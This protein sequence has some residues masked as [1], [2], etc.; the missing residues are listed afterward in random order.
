[1]AKPYSEHTCSMISELENLWSTVLCVATF[2]MITKNSISRLGH[3]TF[4]YG[5]VVIIE[6]VA[7]K[8]AVLH[9]FFSSEVIESICSEYDFAMMLER[10]ARITHMTSLGLVMTFEE[11]ARQIDVLHKLS[12]IC[13]QY[14]FAMS[15]AMG[16]PE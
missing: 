10:V 7:T 3:M 8:R 15:F 16:A 9:K 11:V 4:S 13:S 14:G 12:S 2:S 6:E 1:M 5:F